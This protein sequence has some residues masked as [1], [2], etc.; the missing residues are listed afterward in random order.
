MSTMNQIT[1]PVGTIYP[2]SI[3]GAEASGAAQLYPC[4]AENAAALRER[5]SWLRP[6]RGT[7]KSYDRG[8][9]S[10]SPMYLY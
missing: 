9:A 6:V 10:G 3:V 4:S 5:L 1:V 8:P 2:G 7:R